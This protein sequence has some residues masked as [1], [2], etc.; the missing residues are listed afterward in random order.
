MVALCMQIVLVRHCLLVGLCVVVGVDCYIFELHIFLITLIRVTGI[1]YLF[2][3]LKKSGSHAAALVLLKVFYSS[4]YIA[5]FH[6]TTALK[7]HPSFYGTTNRSNINLKISF[8]VTNNNYTNTLC[9]SKPK[10][11]GK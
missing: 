7:Y 4:S 9:V 3:M 1:P 8:L 5:Y 10:Q 2:R 11:F 6:S